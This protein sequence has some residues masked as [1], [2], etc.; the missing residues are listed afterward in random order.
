MLVR[1]RAESIRTGFML[2]QGGEFAFV[3]LSLASQLHVL[4][5]EL[6]AS[7]AACARWAVLWSLHSVQ[8]YLHNSVTWPFTTVDLPVGCC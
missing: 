4:P 1:D 6:R 8:P 7:S 2:S 5:D 3:L